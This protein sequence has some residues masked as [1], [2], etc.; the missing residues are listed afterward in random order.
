MGMV[1]I[2]KGLEGN[3]PRLSPLFFL[4]GGKR[5]GGKQFLGIFRGAPDSGRCYQGKIFDI[6]FREAVA[7]IL[8][9]KIIEV[10]SAE[11]VVAVTGDDL[12]H[13]E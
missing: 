8:L 3:S 9:N 4:D 2:L 11:A 7:Q 6:V 12:N 10:V 1:P 5:L 13:I